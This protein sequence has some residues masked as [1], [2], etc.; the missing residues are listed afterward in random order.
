[1]YR[2][3]EFI[4]AYLAENRPHDSEFGILQL[5][6][7]GRIINWEGNVARFN[8]SE[9]EL[10]SDAYNYSHVLEATFPLTKNPTF[11]PRIET[12]KDIFADIHFIEYEG[13]NWVLYIDC[14]EEVH[15][16]RPEI[17]NHNDNI[18]RKHNSNE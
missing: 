10:Y 5:N 1:M 8:N 6:Q 7:K 12:Q 15:R 3:P 14:T 11:M 16:I 4:E 17:Q 9:P 13:F 18:L 2:I